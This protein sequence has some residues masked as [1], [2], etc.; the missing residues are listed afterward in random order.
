M[1][2]HERY[3]LIACSPVGS[4]HDV[5]TGTTPHDAQEHIRSNFGVHTIVIKEDKLK[6]ICPCCLR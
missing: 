4:T 2:L 6:I 3:K 5:P 1:T